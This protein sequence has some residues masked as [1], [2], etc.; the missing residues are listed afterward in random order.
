MKLYEA[1]G[2]S[3]A[4]KEC[5]AVVGAGG[6]TSTMY[7]L[8]GELRDTG[9]K[10]V[11]TTTTK[12]Y[13]PD[14]SSYDDI[15]ISADKDKCLDFAAKSVSP[16]SYAVGKSIL[17]DNKVE[18]LDR[19]LICKMFESAG[20]SHIIVEADGAKCKPLKAPAGHEPV[21]PQCATV[22]VGVIG[23]DAV[24]KEIN[25]EN[26]HRVEKFCEIC[27]CSIG[28]TVNMD[29]LA[30]LIRHPDGLFKGTPPSCGRIV[31]LNKAEGTERIEA[32][33][34]IKKEFLPYEDVKVLITSLI[35]EECIIE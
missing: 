10:V 2:I 14:S 20:I 6:K 18:G 13:M 28:E 34:K 33:N 21:I 15:I 27:N 24:G 3:P 32:A 7:R 23:L 1:M 35:G 9:Q 8:S 19:D 17:P 22:V 30:A 31:M 29:M 25:N 5:V 16:G 11:I 26:I 12:I 4:H